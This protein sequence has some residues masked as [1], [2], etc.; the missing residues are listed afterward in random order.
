MRINEYNLHLVI[1]FRAGSGPETDYFIVV[2][3]SQ[4]LNKLQLSNLAVSEK[5]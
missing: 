1:I 4:N 5:R 2:A 3:L